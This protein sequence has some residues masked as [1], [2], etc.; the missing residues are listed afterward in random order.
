M[1]GSR[2]DATVE[3][4]LFPYQSR[5]EWSRAAR[6]SS[7]TRVSSSPE[8]TGGRPENAWTTLLERFKDQKAR[9]R[10]DPPGV[11]ASASDTRQPVKASTSQN[12]RTGVSVERAAFKKRFRS[13]SVRYLRRPR[14]SKSCSMRYA[15]PRCRHGTL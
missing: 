5:G 2:Y 12:A 7:R 10:I 13:V 11:R 9:R 6:I 15:V 8:G 1:D 3:T 4:V 14:G